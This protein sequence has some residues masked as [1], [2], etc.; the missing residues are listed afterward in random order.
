[1]NSSWPKGISVG[2]ESCE[3]MESKLKPNIIKLKI[4]ACTG[5]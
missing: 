3:S 5:V 2:L 4:F 1:M